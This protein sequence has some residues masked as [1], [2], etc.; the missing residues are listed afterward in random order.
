MDS[1]LD[2]DNDRLDLEKKFSNMLETKLIKVS[3]TKVSNVLETK[4]SNYNILM[5]MTFPTLSTLKTFA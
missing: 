2:L 3:N 1:K 4:V 5:I